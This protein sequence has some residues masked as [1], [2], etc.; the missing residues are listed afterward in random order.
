M[1][2]YGWVKTTVEIADELARRMKIEAATRGVTIE[3]ILIEALQE[4]LH[5]SKER[6]ARS[7]P[8]GGPAAPACTFAPP[9]LA[10]PAAHDDS[11]PPGRSQ[12]SRA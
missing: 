11:G 5:R 10:L 8:T 3:Q 9:P 1:R 12:A 7:R 4:R 6:R 2:Q